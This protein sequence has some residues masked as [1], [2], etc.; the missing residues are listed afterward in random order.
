MYETVTIAPLEALMEKFPSMSVIVPPTLPFII[1][2]APISGVSVSSTTVPLIIFCA[3]KL[4]DMTRA[5][6]VMNPLWLN[7]LV[8]I[9]YII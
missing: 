2:V 3:Y 8:I 6:R 1:T 4:M 9:L 7:V 5:K